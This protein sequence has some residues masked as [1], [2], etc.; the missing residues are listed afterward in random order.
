MVSR[1]SAGAC[2]VLLLA[3]GG[4]ARQDP[5]P[6]AGLKHLARQVEEWR[7]KASDASMPKPARLEAAR[8]LGKVPFEKAADVLEGLLSPAESPD[9][10]RAGVEALSAHRDPRVGTILIRGWR[11]YA[12]ALRQAVI[13]ALLCRPERLA[14][15]LD[16]LESGR[17]PAG[18]LEANPREALLKHS[19]R[20]IRER[21]SRIFEARREGNRREIVDSFRAGMKGL[22]GDPAEGRVTYCERCAG[23]HEPTPLGPPVGPQLGGTNKAPEAILV[24]IVDPHRDVQA[25]FYSYAVTTWDGTTVTG[26]LV[27][28]TATSVT[29]R[30]ADAA[31]DTILRKDIA[32]LRSSTLSFMPEG[33]GKDLTPLQM[34][35]LIRYVQ[36]LKKP[37]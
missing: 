11:N 32:S 30:R 18:H 16:A 19:D 24:G 10:Q 8:I 4:H 36:S 33:L 1:I 12:P 3:W 2:L 6:E 26:M 34:A 31:Q 14:A 25:N 28:E 23:C 35:D 20:P 7:R 9:L 17:V 37:E 13:D 27:K 22:E 5:D 29:L 21:A 15:L